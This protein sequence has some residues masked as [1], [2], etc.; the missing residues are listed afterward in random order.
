MQIS[1]NDHPDEPKAAAVFAER[2]E[3]AERCRYAS[4]VCSGQLAVGKSKRNGIF[5]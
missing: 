3:Q 5:G 1:A 2:I 4:A